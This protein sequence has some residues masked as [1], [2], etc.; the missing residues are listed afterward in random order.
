MIKFA[1]FVAELKES[2]IVYSKRIRCIICQEIMHS[3]VQL[4]P[5]YRR[6]NLSY[7]DS[8]IAAI[9]IQLSR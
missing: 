1:K 4:I 7:P 6:M 2:C 5:A 8:R 9:K 3:G